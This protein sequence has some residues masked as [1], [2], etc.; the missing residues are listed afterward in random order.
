[1]IV[2]YFRLWACPCKASW[3]VWFTLGDGLTLLRLFLGRIRLCLDI[4][5]GT[6]L[7]NHWFIIHPLLDWWPYMDRETLLCCGTTYWPGK[8]E[9]EKHFKTSSVN[10]SWKEIEQKDKRQAKILYTSHDRL[11][12]H[13]CWFCHVLN[14]V[15]FHSK[16]EYI[17]YPQFERCQ[18]EVL[19]CRIYIMCCHI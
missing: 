4:I 1:M 14:K 9:T 10:W 2:V 19:W 16:Y 7:K 3:T 13:S 6:S 12:F 17:D 11:V 5:T 18:M 8:L 15:I